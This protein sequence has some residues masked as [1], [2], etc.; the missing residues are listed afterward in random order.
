MNENERE[1][2]I[3]GIRD[4]NK[5]P[6]ERIGVYKCSLNEFGIP[7]KGCVLDREYDKCGFSEK[8]L[9]NKWMPKLASKC[10]TKDWGYPL[11]I[12]SYLL[13]EKVVYTI[14]KPLNRKATGKDATVPSRKRV[15]PEKRE[16]VVLSPKN[17]K[18]LSI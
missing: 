17:Y 13:E 1:I 2:K 15:T 5:L 4:R 12:T 18:L 16:A 9:I 11:L 6:P 10:D 7:S 3:P 14:K 8:L